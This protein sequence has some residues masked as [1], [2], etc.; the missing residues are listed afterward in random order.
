MLK[1]K[2]AGQACENICILYDDG[3][4]S[5]SAAENGSFAFVLVILM[6]KMIVQS[7]NKLMK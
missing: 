3:T 1:V 5:K 4:S 2:N 6:C 7:L